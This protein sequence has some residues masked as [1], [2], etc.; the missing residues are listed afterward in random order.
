MGQVTPRGAETSSES[1]REDWLFAVERKPVTSLKD[2]DGYTEKDYLF[3]IYGQSV[4]SEDEIL[5]LKLETL[6]V[7]EEHKAPEVIKELDIRPVTPPA[8]T[9]S[10]PESDS[11]DSGIRKADAE[12]HEEV[13]TILVPDSEVQSEVRSEIFPAAE[14]VPVPFDDEREVLNVN[15]VYDEEY[16]T[17][18]TVR[19]EEL[20]EMLV[21][22]SFTVCSANQLAD[23]LTKLPRG[24]ARIILEPKEPESWENCCRC[25]KYIPAGKTIRSC[26]WCGEHWF[27]AECFEG[28][29]IER[30]EAPDDN[31]KPPE[32]LATI[33]EELR[34][35]HRPPRHQRRC[36]D[37]NRY[38]I[39]AHMCSVPDGCGY[40]I[41]ERCWPTHACFHPNFDD[42]SGKR[43]T[44]VK[45]SEAAQNGCG[46]ACDECKKRLLDP[47]TCL[48]CKKLFCEKHGHDH[49]G[50]QRKLLERFD[51]RPS[52]GSSGVK[53]I[54]PDDRMKIQIPENWDRAIQALG[55]P[56]ST[57]HLTQ[58]WFS[59]T[60]VMGALVQNGLRYEIWQVPDGSSGSGVAPAAPLPKQDKTEQSCR[61]P[62]GGGDCPLC[63]KG[64]RLAGHGDRPGPPNVCDDW[65]LPTD[66]VWKCN[67]GH[68]LICNECLLDHD[69]LE[70]I[71]EPCKNHEKRASP[72]GPE[73]ELLPGASPAAAGAWG[74]VPMDAETL[75]PDPVSGLKCK[76]CVL[77]CSQ[78]RN[79]MDLGCECNED[80][81]RGVE[82]Y[83]TW[84]WCRR[85]PLCEMC[86]DNQLSMGMC[87]EC[88]YCA[89]KRRTGWCRGKLELWLR[90]MQ[91]CVA[92]G[93]DPTEKDKLELMQI[94]A[95]VNTLPYLLQKEIMTCHDIGCWDCSRVVTIDKIHICDPC[96]QLICSHCRQKHKKYCAGLQKK[97]GDPIRN[98]SLALPTK[99]IPTH[100]I[101]LVDDIP[102]NDGAECVRCADGGMM[103]DEETNAWP[104]PWCK[105]DHDPPVR[106]LLPVLPAEGMTTMQRMKLTSGLIS[107]EQ[108]MR[109]IYFYQ[110][111]PYLKMSRMIL[112]RPRQGRTVGADL[113]SF[114]KCKNG[115]DADA[116]MMRLLYNLKQDWQQM[117]WLHNN[118]HQKGDIVEK[119]MDISELSANGADADW[120]VLLKF[121][122]WDVKQVSPVCVED[123]TT[124]K[125]L[126]SSPPDK[127]EKPKESCKCTF[128]TADGE[129][130]CRRCDRPVCWEH[131][132]RDRCAECAGYELLSNGN[133][134]VRPEFVV[135]APE[136]RARPTRGR[137][138]SGRL[139]SGST[140]R[141][142]GC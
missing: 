11:T 93:D 25:G 141:R 35:Q 54:H 18:K 47:V 60:F 6:T 86:Y 142:A 116:D 31:T 55:T 42:H 103:M 26:A 77:G 69:C 34:P 9:D 118:Y 24:Q 27:D 49:E 76:N 7:S 23:R 102:K 61:G 135:P 128:C 111:K 134:R 75:D 15:I 30:S 137:R 92:E 114:E 129:A 132:V 106:R 73:E 113:P 139:P 107:G 63:R 99:P 105:S 39:Q 91:R 130:R 71:C 108:A 90:S 48:D 37:C 96:A 68:C 79:M 53:T 5:E 44:A 36:V 133:W 109:V 126:P 66:T 70:K 97:L 59:S 110:D 28:H 8:A 51:W 85:A 125:H 121:L 65:R 74:Q 12:W 56:E 57:Y 95:N 115:D 46:F 16:D 88:R 62:P 58:M 10:T 45:W 17:V 2:E 19:Q 40:Y 14:A 20:P 94:K 3:D 138:R 131:R 21:T 43:D 67:Q 29:V 117:D 13:E 52:A 104:C 84:D 119:M 124:W 22:R 1:E 123:N 89:N 83:T 98:S 112:F 140:R 122:D 50:C 82:A 101:L 127:D 72:P 4:A 78:K 38:T 32:K 136:S 64:R 33:Q 120:Q 87:P 81:L 41:C 100:A 80:Q